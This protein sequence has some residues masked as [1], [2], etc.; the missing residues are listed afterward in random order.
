M[1]TE[2]YKEY[3]QTPIW[4]TRRNRSLKLANYRCQRCAAGR[5]LQVHHRTYVR[6]G[7]EWDE[8]LEVL[9]EGCHRGVTAQQM[10]DAPQSRVY[11]KL[12]AEVLKERP[13]LSLADLAYDVKDRCRLLHV[14]IDVVAIDKALSVLSAS[15]RMTSPPAQTVA[16]VHERLADTRPISHAEAQECLTRLGLAAAIKT[17]PRTVSKI[18]IYGPVPRDGEW[19]EHDRY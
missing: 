10:H 6:L 7:A 14:P 17:M 8:D 2:S 15:S 12:A 3:L 5:A 11:L 13:F 9:C 19:V 4:R 18:D 16:D 1:N